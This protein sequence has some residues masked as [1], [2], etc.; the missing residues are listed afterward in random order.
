MRN[1][2]FCTAFCSIHMIFTQQQLLKVP[3]CACSTSSACSKPMG[4][5]QERTRKT[6]RALCTFIPSETTQC[7][8]FC[9]STA[10]FIVPSQIKIH[11]ANVNNRESN[12]QVPKGNW[13]KMETL[14]R[15]SSYIFRFLRVLP[16]Y[17][18]RDK[19][20][21]EHYTKYFCDFFLQ[22]LFFFPLPFQ[23]LSIASVNSL[24]QT[25]PH[26]MSGQVELLISKGRRTQIQ[27]C[28]NFTD[29]TGVTGHCRWIASIY[30]HSF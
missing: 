2:Y 9:L 29:F 5:A 30:R 14:L 17:Y 25:F 15:N 18:R 16:C 3:V 28:C 20:E 11:S 8:T 7:E 13:P 23:I 1:S 22:L 6:K 12:S 24:R 21:A 4:S 27:S 19:K 10:P 26:K